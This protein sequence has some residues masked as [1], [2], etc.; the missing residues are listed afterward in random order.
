MRVVISEMCDGFDI[1]LYNI[2]GEMVSH[3]H[4]DQEDSVQGLVGVF[5]EMGIPAAY[6]ESY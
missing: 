2:E 3:H 1:D 5:Q 4:F 6:E